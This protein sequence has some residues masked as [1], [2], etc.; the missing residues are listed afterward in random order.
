MA[1][2]TVRPPRG[3]SKLRAVH[4]VGFSPGLAALAALLFVSLAVA[5]VLA[6]GDRG[7]R[8]ARGIREALD[9]RLASLGYRL[10]VVHLQGATE[11]ARADIVAA[12]KLPF[13][14]PILTL[15]LAGI[16]ARVE[17]SGWVASA[18]VIRLLPDTLVIAVVQRPLMAI[19][20]HAGHAVVVA[21]NGAVLEHMN[22]A[23]FPRLPLIVGPGANLAAAAVLPRIAARPRLA[24]RLQALVRVD[25]RRWDLR[26]GDGCQ[27][28]LPAENVEAG[29]EKLD[30]LDRESN[31]LELRL[32][33][34]DLRDPEMVIV[35]P[36]GLPPPPK[37]SGV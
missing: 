10:G 9:T 3:P 29:L 24:R 28:L 5:A 32:A 31:L 14:A 34:V 36:A 11:A 7:P 20:E 4:G 26:L 30:T 22:P 8:L 13:G 6:T 16:R 1:R 2:G 15:D 18:R 37:T 12:A 23:D 33:R 19:W 27:I 17:R 35:R 25:G 21:S